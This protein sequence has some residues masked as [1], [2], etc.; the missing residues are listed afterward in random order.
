MSELRN[1]LR[2]RNKVLRNP[3][4]KGA[5]ELWDENRL[6]KPSSPDVPLAGLHKARLHWLGATPAMIRESQ[7]WLADHGFNEEI[8]L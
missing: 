7:Q 1:Y 2:R 5:M 8:G 3:T 4:M 6:G